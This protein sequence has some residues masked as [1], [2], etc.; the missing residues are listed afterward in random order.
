MWQ[1]N[2]RATYTVPS[3][4]GAVAEMTVIRPCVPA[5]RAF[6]RSKHPIVMSFRSVPAHRQT[7]RRRCTVHLPGAFPLD[8]LF[9]RNSS[10][11]LQDRHFG[12]SGQHFPT[13]TVK[14]RG[15]DEYMARHAYLIT[16]YNNF[17]ILRILLR[18]LDDE[19]NDIFLHVDKRTSDVDFE[20]LHWP[21]QKSKLT[22]VPR[23][24]VYWGD[25]SQVR[26]VIGL[27]KAATPGS[28][29]YYHLLSGCDLPLKTQDFIHD[30]MARNDG[31]EFIEFSESY[32][33]DWVGLRHYFNYTLKP[34]NRFQRLLQR[35]VAKPLVRVQKACGVDRMRGN[36]RTV[37]KGSDWFSIGHGLAEYIIEN[38]E[39][40]ERL[41]KYA[42]VPT[43]FYVQTLVWNS[44]FRDHIYDPDKN[45]SGNLR[46][47]DW[48]RGSPYT[49][50]I[51]DFPSLV[52]SDLLFARK[53]DW[54]ID[55]RVVEQIAAHLAD[56]VEGKPND[57][58]R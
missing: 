40:L 21:G 45:G 27:L 53:F 5:M 35:R 17:S 32:D 34:A 47:I 4:T 37:R 54:A 11:P 46:Y 30:F 33:K 6:K 18:L 14:A 2:P 20:K 22:I 43:E 52:K 48:K 29:G 8:D 41:F 56:A 39:L 23:M 1:C 58:K 19:R 49:F 12:L 13:R 16:A 10:S 3:Q 26:S 57:G 7:R 25:Y 42:T 44:S 15:S 9:L 51:E 55:S 31:Y 38:E 24:N 36:P 28:Y 50:R